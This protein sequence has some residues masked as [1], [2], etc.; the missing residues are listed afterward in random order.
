MIGIIPA[1][2]SATRMRRIPK[3][4]LPV[5]TTGDTLFT[6][7]CERMRSAGIERVL[8]AVSDATAGVIAPFCTPDILLYKT[9]VP[10]MSEAVILGK[11]HT[12]EGEACFFGMPDTYFEDAEAFS[13]LG[14]ALANNADVAVGLFQTRPDQ[15][16][17]LGMCRVQRTRVLE[18]IDKPQETTLTQA[19]GVLAWKPVFWDCMQADDPHVGYALPRAIEAGLDVRAVPMDGCYWDAGTSEEYFEL[20]G[21]FV[22]T[23]AKRIT[24]TYDAQ[25]E[26]ARA[27]RVFDLSDYRQSKEWDAVAYEPKIDYGEE[28]T[29]RPGFHIFGTM[30]WQD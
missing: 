8:V 4:T 3:M 26:M 28:P 25:R 11:Q 1:G 24:D 14:A 6:V 20:I 30:G 19:W 10:T 23:E 16:K 27:K 9:A 15:H 12:Y 13:K 21:R 7:L 22:N 2:G 5:P 29:L 18:V 17:K